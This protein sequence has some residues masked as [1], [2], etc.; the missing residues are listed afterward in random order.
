M[1]EA[2]LEIRETQETWEEILW[3][4][5]N[6]AKWQI[7]AKEL[8]TFRGKLAET[9]DLLSPEEKELLIANIRSQLTKRAR[10]Y[11]FQ[12]VQTIRD[13][14]LSLLK[15]FETDWMSAVAQKVYQRVKIKFDK[16]MQ[17][18]SQ[19]TILLELTKLYLQSQ[20]QGILSIASGSE[21]NIAQLVYM[22]WWAYSQVANWKT[23]L[24]KNEGG[25]HILFPED[26]TLESSA[27]RLLYYIVLSDLEG[28]EDIFREYNP[29]NDLQ[30]LHIA[31]EEDWKIP[32]V[33]KQKYT[34]LHNTALKIFKQRQ[35]HDTNILH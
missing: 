6:I 12:H 19:D 2:L 3:T 15:T 9:R 1:S 23:I 32:E 20:G 17:I 27:K 34:E 24:S 21:W 13:H 14:V 4:L 5:A 35:P 16:T 31:T 7:H 26:R 29:Q 33:L 30:A 11:Y 28:Y 25:S 22:R 8:A 18:P 10:L